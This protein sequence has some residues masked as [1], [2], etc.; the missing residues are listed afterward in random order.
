MGVGSKHK[1]IA[2][3]ASPSVFNPSQTAFL[4]WICF[5]VPDSKPPMPYL[6][7]RFVLAFCCDIVWYLFLAPIFG[8]DSDWS[9]FSLLPNCLL[10][11]KS[12]HKLPSQ[13]N[14]LTD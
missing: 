4:A 6:D 12:K 1:C 7:L 10:I 13:N 2:D 9:R 14:C 3:S 5:F 8:V 11:V